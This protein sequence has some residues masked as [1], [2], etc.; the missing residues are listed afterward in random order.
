MA[1]WE[2]V[3]AGRLRDRISVI[4]PPRKNKK[5][6]APIQAPRGDTKLFTWLTEV[7]VAAVEEV[8][9]KIGGVQ[10]VLVVL[11]P[12]LFA[13]GGGTVEHGVFRE[14]LGLGVAARRPVDVDCHAILFL[15]GL[16]GFAHLG[17]FL[18]GI[19]KVLLHRFVDLRFEFFAAFFVVVEELVEDLLVWADMNNIKI[20]E[21]Q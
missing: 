18:L 10:L 5:F 19:G 8:E 6:G 12:G 14:D 17:E 13:V 7:V 3:T 2:Y 21:L 11:L 9:M 15:D 16:D 4:P 20:E 1:G